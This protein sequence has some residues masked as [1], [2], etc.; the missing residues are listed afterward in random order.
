MGLGKLLRDLLGKRQLRDEEPAAEC[1]L[2]IL[3]GLGNPGAEYAGTRHNMGFEVIDLLAQFLGAGVKKNKFGALTGEVRHGSKKLILM[4]P[5]EFMNRSGQAVATAAGFY[6]LSPADI[7]VIT[8]DMALEPGKIRLRA[9][10]SAGGHNGLADIIQKLGTV[11][12]SRLRVGIGKAPGPG[13]RDWVLTRPSPGDRK[14]M[15]AA[16]MRARD[17]ALCWIEKGT[18]AAMNSFNA[19]EDAAGQ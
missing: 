16:V 19:A 15:D 12:F 18:A 2:R 4:K 17:A 8:D 7:L 13:W 6:K 1:Q 14:L 9:S 3:V 11:E 10:G 5:Q